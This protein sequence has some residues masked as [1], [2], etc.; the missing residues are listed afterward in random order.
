MNSNWQS[1]DDSEILELIDVKTAKN[2]FIPNDRAVFRIVKIIELKLKEKNDTTQ[3][4][5]QPCEG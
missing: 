2:I 3:R 5:A 4:T 1:L